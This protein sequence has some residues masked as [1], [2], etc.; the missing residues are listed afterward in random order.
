MRLFRK[1]FAILVVVLVLSQPLS[2]GAYSGDVEDYIQRMI[3]YYL[4]HQENADQEIAVLLEYLE[5]LDPDTAAMWRRVMVSWAQ[6]NGRMALNEGILPDGLPCDDSLCIVIMG[7]DL[8]ADG[9]MR[10][11]LV[12]RLVAGLSSALKYLTATSSHSAPSA[13]LKP[14][15]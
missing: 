7:Y 6:C 10:E 2:A 4:Q 8:R 9:S 12:D 1:F 3:Q 13:A 15:A 14:C 5:E 11:E